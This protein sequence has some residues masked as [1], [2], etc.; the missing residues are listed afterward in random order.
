[1]PKGRVTKSARIFLAD[2]CVFTILPLGT[3]RQAFG[4]R[5]RFGRAL[6]LLV[7][8]DSRYVPG[9]MSPSLTLYDYVPSG[10]GYKVRLL[11]HQLGKPFRLVEKQILRGETRTSEFLEKNPN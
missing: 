8:R 5:T 1:M 10:N 4:Q 7:Q 11:L 3:A 2:G 9:G 6:R